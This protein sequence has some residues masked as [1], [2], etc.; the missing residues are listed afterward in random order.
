MTEKEKE[1]L[2]TF[3]R[4]RA[5]K[6]GISYEKAVELAIDI[7]KD[8]PQKKK[9]KPGYHVMTKQEFMRKALRDMAL[10]EGGTE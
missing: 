4:K 3:L 7:I 6:A 8:M 5:K 2:A 1:Q 9:L 10:R